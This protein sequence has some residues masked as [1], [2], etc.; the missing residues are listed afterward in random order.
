MEIE[1]MWTEEFRPKKLDDVA[2]Q[3]GVVS[4]LKTFASQRDIPHLLFAGPP[5]VGKTTCAYALLHEIYPKGF[6]GNVKAMNASDDRGIDIV[7]KDI[8]DFA[9]LIPRD[10]AQFKVILLDEADQMTRDAQHALRRTMERFHRSTRFI[11]TCNYSSRIIDAIQSRCALFRFTEIPEESI[12]N[13]LR[14]IAK[15]KNLN[16]AE[17]GFNA[18]IEVSEG[19]LRR[20]INTLQASAAVG[21]KIS[22]EIVYMIRSYAK[23]AEIEEIILTCL[24]PN[25][26]VSQAFERSQRMV[27]QLFRKYGLSGTDVVSHF[28]RVLVEMS[29]KKISDSVRVEAISLLSDVD[30]RI[31]EGS[32]PVI[33]IGGFLA[34]LIKLGRV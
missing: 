26:K 8:K 16:V 13:R 1:K 4:S 30:F 19:D 22:E 5:G 29:S 28:N 31:S 25:Q 24:D 20:A 14:E 12:K 3:E 15:L 2:G 32:N 10:G 34:K 18:L 27:G 33:Q 23:P 7:R 21:Q 9:S 11:L 6:R 17:G